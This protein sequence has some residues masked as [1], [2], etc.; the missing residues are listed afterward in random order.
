L[1]LK[2]KDIQR[3]NKQTNGA[4]LGD[5]VLELVSRQI[6]IL[7]T[8]ISLKTCAVLNISFIRFEFPSAPLP[9]AKRYA[10]EKNQW[11]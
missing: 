6:R 4:K 10:S 8:D 7:K 3:V 2:A 11:I 5:F 1:T 9:F